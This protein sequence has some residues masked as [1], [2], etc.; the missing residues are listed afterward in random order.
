MST[1]YETLLETPRETIAALL[2]HCGLPWDDRCL[3]FHTTRRS[4]NTA[5]MRQVRKP[6]YKSSIGSWKPVAEELAE[7]RKI[8]GYQAHSVG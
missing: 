4:V 8:L 7:L 6:L 3:T 1:Q 5:S 2:D